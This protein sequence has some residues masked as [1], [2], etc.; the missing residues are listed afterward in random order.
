MIRE[1]TLTSE[2]RAIADAPLE[3][4]YIVNAGAGTGKTYTLV[5]RAVRLVET[6][7]LRADELLVVTFTKKASNEI[8]ERLAL[9]FEDIGVYD[10]PT[11][12][13]FHSLA[14]ALLREFAYVTGDSPDLRAID[15]VRA[16]GLFR[17][18]YADLLAGNL[19]VDLSALPILDRE[20]VLIHDLA[21]LAF[22]LKNE[23]TSIERFEREALAAAAVLR[24]LPFGQTFVR[25]KRGGTTAPMPKRERTPAERS[26]EADRETTNV[27]AVAALLR[28][29]DV[30]LANE[31]V[32]TYGDLLT[33]AIAM[34]EDHPTVADRIRRRW[35]H[36]LVDE[37]QDT[38][39][40]QL[41][42]LR[43][44]F[45]N[46]LRSVM[47]VGDVR[48]AIYEWNGADPLGIVKLK[49]VPGTQT[50][51]LTLNR[52][53]HREILEAAHTILPK[54]G[55]IDW[56]E[57]LRAHLGRASQPVVRHAVFEDG[58]NVAER[59]ECEARAI[60]AEIAAL[61]ADG[62]KPRD[63]AI[64][65]R[66]RPAARTYA[67]ALR[68]CGIPSR[69]HGGVGFFDAPEI[70][71]AIAWFRLALDPSDRTALARVLQS[72]A[73]AFSDGTVA[74]LF[75]ST[76][77]TSLVLAGS[78]PPFL[79]SDEA[80]RFERI[81]STLAVVGRAVGLRVT[82]AVRTLVRE[83]A[84][85]AARI[86]ANQPGAAQIQANIAKL[87][88][89]ADGFA[90]DRPVARL[91]DFIAEIDERA[92]L[93]DDE[94]EA[95]LG[96]DEV[97]IMT[98]HAAKGLE[99]NHVFIANVTPSTFPSNR[100]P[101][102]MTVIRDAGSRALAFRY[103]VDGRMPLRW[104]LRVPHDPETGE[105]QEASTRDDSEER[106]LFY[107]AVTRAKRCVWISGVWSSSGK[108][109]KFLEELLAHAAGDGRA[110]CRV[111]PEP[112]S[113]GASDPAL[114]IAQPREL[115]L[116]DLARLNARLT[117][118]PS[119]FEPWRGKLSYTAISTFRTCPRQARY[120]YALQVPD[121]R[122]T[123]DV[124][125]ADFDEPAGYRRTID[126]ATYGNIVHRVLEWAAR[127][128]IDGRSYQLATLVDD[129]LA[130]FESDG[131][132]SLRARVMTAAQR[133]LDVLSE[134]T[135][136]GAEVE[137]DTTIAGTSIGGFVDL[138]TR[139]RAH[140]IWIVDYKTGRIPDD[141]FALQLALYRI[142]LREKY[143]HARLAILRIADEGVSLIEPPIPPDAT[144]EQ[145]VRAAAPMDRDEAHTGVQ[146]GTCPYAGRLCPEGEAALR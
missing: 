113:R 136:V 135:P 33:R 95:E 27:R 44:I 11:C 62:Q 31:G 145:I 140:D 13:T 40:Q 127:A 128:G 84:I 138:V 63:I 144:V 17:R 130:E 99:W 81:R 103:G 61:V 133:S 107:V 2:Q 123:P 51:P 25:G 56:G 67:N 14:A 125:L 105:R 89:L 101:G 38:N 36:A 131:D 74:R 30:L 24:S 49:E 20:E 119:L 41:T 32:L 77:D 47:A 19:G 66:S 94:A 55:P 90:Q 97:A 5:R 106:R 21:T 114:Q 71:D 91:G 35:R 45:G 15:D 98:I 79:D 68:D 28:H 37:F 18:A 12:E 132:A 82:D 143:P 146:C 100:G 50:F 46:D 87:V 142:A 29:F 86:A 116:P 122:E 80:R 141:A 42:F 53:S 34:F 60:A 4:P 137:F 104:H 109:S 72:P 83:T 111:F 57:P 1:D 9:A 52:R 59:R 23:G 112:E 102:E 8:A 121:F 88:S 70:V 6:K 43:A 64:L 139:D 76:D 134:Y 16:R 126:S 69:T 108:P 129:A 26:A 118:Q 93:E 85:D 7:A 22:S 54:D 3:G 115:P 75:A 48:Q 117:R 78:A 110:A 120:R 73:A 39:P 10:L 65:L 96:G 92:L 58:A 124:E